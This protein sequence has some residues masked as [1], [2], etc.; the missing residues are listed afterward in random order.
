MSTTSE[1]P[2][3]I[4]LAATPGRRPVPFR[5]VPDAEARA[6]IAGRLGLMD[7]KKLR[8]EGEIAPAGGA[9]WRL[10]ARLGTTVVQP[11]VVTLAPVTTR[12]DTEVARSYRADMPLVP[13]G[14]EVEMPADETAEPLP[15]TLDLAV[16]MEEALALALPLY[17]R[18]DGVAHGEA[19]YGPPGVDPLRDEDTKPFAA[20]AKLKGKLRE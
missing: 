2:R 9:D 17:P 13:E 15:E 7:L 8:F 1:T 6:A 19:V 16:V 11:C 14:D 5:L 3:T 18:A 12:I 4:R 20:L 10:A